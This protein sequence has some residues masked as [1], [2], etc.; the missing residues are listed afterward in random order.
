LWEAAP[1]AMQAAL[2]RHDAIVRFEVEAHGGVVFATGG[3]GFAVAFD[4]AG[5]AVA[6]ACAAQAALR[7]ERWPERAQIRVRMGLHT[8]EASERSGDYFGP[9]VNRAARLMA[10]G[11]GGQVVCSEVT[12]TLAED[13]AEVVDL[14]EHRLRDLSAPQ[15]VFQVGSGKFPPL[16]SL[17]PAVTNLPV[18]MTE[19][20]GRDT[21]I[22]E[23]TALLGDHRVVTL[24]GV[25]GVGKTRLA[26]AAAAAVAPA[27][28]DGCRLV[29]LATVGTDEEVPGAVSAA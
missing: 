9:A 29:E 18:V 28:S 11:H 10:V 23:I 13:V 17:S 22:A 4:R 24:T 19:L 6:A 16:R 7:E 8:G 12:A 14:G 1:E 20:I 25:G 27:F 21:D 3:D 5:D 26:L 15:R 2:E